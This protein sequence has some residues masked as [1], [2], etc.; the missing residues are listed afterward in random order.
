MRAI[1]DRSER[2]RGALWVLLSPRR[3]FF[4]VAER[5][6]PWLATLLLCLLGALPGLV[7]VARADL[8]A[9][10]E[11]ELVRSGRAEDMPEE[12][13]KAALEVGPRLLAVAI[14]IGGAGKRAAWILVLGL[15]GFGFLRGTSKTLRLSQAFAAVAVGAAPLAL[16]DLF[17]ALV[18]LMR[19]PLSVDAKNPL[20]SNPAAWLALD[21]K[22]SVLGA[23]LRRLDLFELWAA[24]LSALGLSVVAKTKSRL[25][26][27]L[28][29]G[30]V[31]VLLAMDVVGAAIAARMA[32]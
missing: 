24:G 27:L 6:R 26:W 1:R 3:A 30:A 20:L 29:F 2:P 14:P 18:F 7:F 22:R 13:R 10:V 11:R 31:C 5:P 8:P 23:A 15:F 17:E 19:D 4:G 16:A 21:V 9:L 28:T 32:R 12:A 25:P